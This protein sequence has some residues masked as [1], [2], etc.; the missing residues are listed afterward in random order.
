[1]ALDRDGLVGQGHPGDPE[2]PELPDQPHE[3][4]MIRLRAMTCPMYQTVVP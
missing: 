4:N 1:L 2:P 3:H